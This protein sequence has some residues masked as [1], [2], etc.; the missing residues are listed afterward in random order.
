MVVIAKINITFRD[1][2]G[3]LKV[4]SPGETVEGINKAEEKRLL[5]L[6]A[7]EKGQ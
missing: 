2:E 5:E 1:K 3:D 6:G 4:F 7:V